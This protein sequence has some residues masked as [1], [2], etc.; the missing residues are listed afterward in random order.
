MNKYEPKTMIIRYYEATLY[1]IFKQYG[2][3][4]SHMVMSHYF[5]Q[6]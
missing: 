1:N 4:I 2:V 6:P 5:V 3:S